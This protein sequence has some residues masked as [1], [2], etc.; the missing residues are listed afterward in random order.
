MVVYTVSDLM[1]KSNSFLEGSVQS[2]VRNSQNGKGVNYERRT[3]KI[4]SAN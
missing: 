3:E 2:Q 1:Q 4:N